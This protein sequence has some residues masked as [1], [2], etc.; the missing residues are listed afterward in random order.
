MSE[1]LAKAELSLEGFVQLFA[2]LQDLPRPVA[3]S[4]FRVFDADG[5]GKLTF[6]EFL[7]SLALCCHL[8]SS[9]SEKMR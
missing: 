8:M 5:N 3:E 4:A 2:E 1:E 7:A 6:R 9:D